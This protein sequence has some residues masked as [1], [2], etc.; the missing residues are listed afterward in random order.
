[1]ILLIRSH[2]TLAPGNIDYLPLTLVVTIPDT[3]N[4]GVID[5]E[6]NCPLIAN[7]DQTDTD[8]DGIGDVCDP[9]DDNDGVLD[10]NDFCPFENATGFDANLD[11]CIDTL[12]GLQQIIKTLLDE[13][14]S[15]EIK[16]SLV[17]KVDNALKSIDKEQ[18]EAA[19]NILEAFISQ[20]TAQRGKKIS[21]EAADMLIAYANN[22]IAQ[23]N[24][25]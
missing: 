2:Y 22:V 14:L 17:S 19:I 18:D 12:I 23:I 16:N 3:D 9:D 13:V 7:P 11:G 15:D 25:E 4:D 20:I 1:M 6:D 10:V 21:E 8:V 5:E 24:T